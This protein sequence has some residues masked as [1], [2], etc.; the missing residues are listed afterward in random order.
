MDYNRSRAY[1]PQTILSSPVAD[2]RRSISEYSPGNNQQQPPEY[3]TPPGFSRDEPFLNPNAFNRI[4]GRD[5]DVYMEE[6]AEKYDQ[7]AAK[8]RDCTMEEWLAGVNG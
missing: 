6:Q 7:L 3:Q 4:L 5:A 1:S 2:S 8:W